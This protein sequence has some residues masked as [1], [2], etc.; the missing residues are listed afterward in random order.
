MT[1]T[2]SSEQTAVRCTVKCFF[3]DSV[4]ASGVGT[5]SYAVQ[6]CRRTGCTNKLSIK[7]QL[8]LLLSL[9]L[10]QGLSMLENN[11]AEPF[12]LLLFRLAAL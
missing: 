7:T 6:E 12:L 9:S 5:S 4:G 10:K 3:V 11:T 8:S 2:V 1:L